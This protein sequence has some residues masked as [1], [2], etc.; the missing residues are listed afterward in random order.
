M[1]PLSAVLPTPHSPLWGEDIG[2]EPFTRVMSEGRGQPRPL[3]MLGRAPGRREASPGRSSVPC[4]APRHGLVMEELR[5]WVSARRGLKLGAMGCQPPESAAA[6]PPSGPGRAVPP[7]PLLAALGTS[8]GEPEPVLGRREQHRSRA[9]GR[10]TPVRPGRATGMSSVFAARWENVI[11]ALIKGKPLMHKPLQAQAAGL[12][13]STPRSQLIGEQGS[14]EAPGSKPQ[15]LCK[16]LI[17]EHCG[18]PPARELRGDLP[19]LQAWLG[20]CVGGGR[21]GSGR[22]RRPGL[23]L[24]AEVVGGSRVRIYF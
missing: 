13:S 14:Q 12:P 1:S 20:G 15:P 7:R 22:A 2:N 9:G 6:S 10:R 19:A 18:L 3:A 23:P 4:S 21:R 16:M 24:A 5:N 11:N 17:G 8:P